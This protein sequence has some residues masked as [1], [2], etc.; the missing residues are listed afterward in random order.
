MKWMSIFFLPIIYGRI[1]WSS[2]NHSIWFDSK[3]PFHL[4]G[5]N[6]FGYEGDCRIVNGLWVQQMDFFLETLSKYQFNSIRIP[7]GYET[8]M[9]WELPPNILCLT[10][11]P[12]LISMNVRDSLHVLFQKTLQLNITI[13][14]D[15]HTISTVIT[16][17]PTTTSVSLDQIVKMWHRIFEQFSR[18]PNFIGVDLKNEPHGNITWTEWGQ[19]VTYI[20]E[21]VE[22]QH[23][24]FQGLFFIEGIQDESD[25]SVW[26]GSFRQMEKFDIGVLPS[27]RVIFSPHVYGTSIRGVIAENDTYALFDTWFGDLRF[28]YPNNAIVLGEV[29][30]MDIGSD[31]EWHEKI[32]NYLIRRNIRDTYYW[33]LNPNS[34]D[35]GGIFEY[36]WYTVNEEKIRFSNEVQPLPTNMFFSF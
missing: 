8:V 21:M 11:N 26:G 30:G 14:L 33:C 22:Q 20:I 32:R 35:T 27:N 23:V 28:R 29:G 6:W 12:W 3:T 13:L 16:E 10:M 4:K 36:D 24:H 19:Y 1:L 9:T 25:G 17:H 34:K 5:V 15:F 31:F 2:F 18:Y 7:F